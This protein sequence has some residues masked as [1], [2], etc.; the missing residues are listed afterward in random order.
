M[1]FHFDDD[2]TAE[3]YIEPDISVKATLVT[4]S[5]DDG[6]DCSRQLDSG[7]DPFFDSA[8]LSES[9]LDFP[10]EFGRTYHAYRAGSYAFPNDVPEQERLALQSSIIKRLFGDR[11]HFAPLDPIRP[12]GVIL[13][14][15]TGVGDWAIE[16]G[17][18][19]PGS[20]VIGTDLSP[21]QPDIVPPNVSFFVDDATD[22]WCHDQPFGYVHTRL[23]GGCWA[24]FEK[25]IAEPAFAALEPGGWFESQE[26]DG[27]V[28]SDDDSLA[29]DSA[30]H[31]WFQEVATAA[32]R[33]NRPANLGHSLREVYERVGFVDVHEHIFKMP[34][35]GW[36]RDERLKEL[37]RLWERNFLQG[38]SG[39]SFQLFNRAYDRTAAQIEVSLVDVRRELSDPTIHAWMPV[40]VVWGRK[41]GDCSPRDQLPPSSISFFIV[42]HHDPPPSQL[43]HHGSQGKLTLSR[44]SHHNGTKRHHPSDG[45]FAVEASGLS[46]PTCM[47]VGMYKPDG[48]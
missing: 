19:F 36:A 10:Q 9:V 34:T 13:D 25:E 6:S 42:K 2:Q 14:V 15:A 32:E 48:P 39:F 31:R 30:M 33:L 40:Y 4:F 41:P 27:L 37:G 45:A 38:L 8:S 47:Y 5:G 1:R 17:D 22:P 12:P 28:F 21:I 23:T 43:V 20:Q 26:I 35:N 16:M 24:S 46:A 29:A 7:V 18:L 3:A 44:H 11:L